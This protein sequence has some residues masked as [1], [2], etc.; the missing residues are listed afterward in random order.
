MLIKSI[1][2]FEKS[3]YIYTYLNLYYVINT[4]KTWL[5]KESLKETGKSF[6]VIIKYILILM[7]IWWILTLV[8]FLWSN[9]VKYD[10]MESFWCI[11][12]KC[13]NFNIENLKWFPIFDD[14]LKYNDVEYLPIWETF[15]VVPMTWNWVYY[16][17]DPQPYSQ[18]WYYR[19]LEISLSWMVAV[20]YHEYEKMN[21][22]LDTRF[23]KQTHSV[24]KWWK[25]EDNNKCYIFRWNARYWRTDYTSGSEE[26]FREWENPNNCTPIFLP[27]YINTNSNFEWLFQFVIAPLEEWVLS[28]WAVKAEYRLWKDR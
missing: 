9:R 27:E 4:M 14:N 17:F 18:W 22:P 15:D 20:V 13:D 10:M 5:D 8:L 21:G 11:F 28:T 12:Y 23:M 7:W 26:E 3:R 19:D 24:T 25:N 1:S 16:K 2:I 6:L